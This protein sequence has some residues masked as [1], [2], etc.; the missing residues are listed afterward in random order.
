M[1]LTSLVLTFSLVLCLIAPLTLTAGVLDAEAGGPRQAERAEREWVRELH[2]RAEHAEREGSA[3][4]RERAIELRAQAEAAERAAQAAAR[5][6]LARETEEGEGA[7]NAPEPISP[8]RPSKTDAEIAR[9]KLI[10]KLV[11]VVVTGRVGGPVGA[12]V[13]ITFLSPSEIGPEPP[14]IPSSQAAPP[15]QDR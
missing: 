15:D 7:V 4:S 9:D 8:R 2:D 6:R 5:E 13:G 14:L 12:F 3:A 11:T 10:G 1:R